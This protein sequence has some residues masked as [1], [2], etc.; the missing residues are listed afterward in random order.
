MDNNNVS[1]KQ[2]AKKQPGIKNLIKHLEQDELVEIIVELSKI[3]KNNEQFLRLFIQGSD[4][5]NKEKIVKEVKPKLYS[6]FFGRGGMPYE[7]IN[8]KAARDIIS[9]HARVLKEFP[10]AVI[11]LKL[12][13]VELGVEV[14]SDWGDMYDAFYDSIGSM[15]ASLCKDLFNNHKFYEDFSEP[16]SSLI[17]KTKGVGWGFHEF[18]CDTI[19]DLQERLGIDDDDY[20][21]EN[22]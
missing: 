8:L 1:Q 22:K 21:D 9:Q 20:E 16:L 19:Y 15:L 2:S 14:M 17:S 6:I 4:N 5:E 18:V 10:E 11:E 3:S 12:Y 13:Y 7:R